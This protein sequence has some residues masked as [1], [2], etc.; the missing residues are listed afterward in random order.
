MAGKSAFTLAEVLI[1]L[2]I[3]GVVAA[4][5]MPSLIASHRA[6][7]LE[8]QFKKRY[9]E[10]NQALAMLQKDNI[11][12]YGNYKTQDIAKV[13]VTSFK[14]AKLG[15]PQDY[16]NNYKNHSKGDAFNIRS[17]DDGL[18]IVNPEFFIFVNNDQPNNSIELFI[19]ING[20]KKPNIFGYDLFEFS[21]QEGD[22]LTTIYPNNTYFCN[23]TNNN[24][25]NGVSC[26]YFALTDKDYFKKLK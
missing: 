9:S 14:D 18:I 1:T 13:L 26:S 8:T 24:I 5:T 23:D 7:V 16:Y 20:D 12:I 22:N 4:L 25:G 15:N 11:T 10:L 17:L 19:D 6:K 21:L 2:G 3:I